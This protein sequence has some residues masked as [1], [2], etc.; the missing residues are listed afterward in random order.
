LVCFP[1]LALSI[2]EEEFH[3]CHGTVSSRILGSLAW[4]METLDL[5]EMLI[6]DGRTLFFFIFPNNF[7][8]KG[9]QKYIIYLA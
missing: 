2:L 8:Q 9:N 7:N 5:A 3:V 4:R 6:T 1:T